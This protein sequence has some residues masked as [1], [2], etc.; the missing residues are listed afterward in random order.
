MLRMFQSLG[1]LSISYGEHKDPY[2]SVR[3][4]K[5]LCVRVLESQ[6]QAST[7]ST[8][9]LQNGLGA[10]TTVYAEIGR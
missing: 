10:L 5:D 3:V 7:A 8:R 2:E 9:S 1:Q 6:V 4:K